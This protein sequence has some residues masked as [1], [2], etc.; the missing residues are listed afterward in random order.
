MRPARRL[1]LLP[2]YLF[3][4][5][6][7]RIAEKRAAGIDVI[8]LGVGDP[9]LPTPPHVV[10]E[11]RWAARDPST[12]G[13]PSYF[14]LP[15]LRRAIAG[16][17]AERFGVELDPHAE[18]LP[19]IGSKEG[20]AHLALAFV[21]PGDEVLVPDPGYPVPA[22][23]A[24]LAGGTPVA[25]PLV[26]ERGL[27]PDLG[28][29]P[30]SAATKVLWLNHPSNPTSSVA[31]PWL[32]E[33]AVALAREHGL[34][35][36]HDAAYSELTYDGYVAPSVLQAPGARDVA[37]EFGSASKTYNMTG[38]R[39]GWAV[40]N[41]DAI[42]ALGT[43]KTNIDSG[44][45]EA[46]QR[47][48]IAALTGPQDHVDAMR[49]VYA[50]R[51]DVVIE[52]L[53]ALGWDLQPPRGAFYVWFPTPHGMSSAAFSEILL[54]RAGVVVSPGAGYGAAGEGYV[55]IALTVSDERLAEAMERIR[56]AL[57]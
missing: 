8:S 54:E 19:L 45:W 53:N 7:R 36:A 5:L 57:S 31:E 11:L 44:I 49:A 55:R 35:L 26:P 22:T 48:A 41:A 33:E 17:Y 30:V 50:K 24:M 23:S 46:V 37:V 6:D 21:D 29:A 4:E 3:A 43:V 18:V 27:L 15:E 38:W 56:E 25:M 14:G 52:A 40:G 47:A 32:F 13:Y 9:D 39:V 1:E 51:R 42:R 10:E 2:P 12:H 20:L 28:A 16:W 34:L